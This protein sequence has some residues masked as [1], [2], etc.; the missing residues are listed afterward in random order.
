[1][2][3][4]LTGYVSAVLLGT[5]SAGTAPALVIHSP[6]FRQDV[7]ENLSGATPSEL[8]GILPGRRASWRM[9]S[10][11]DKD[12]PGSPDDLD[13]PFRSSARDTFRLVGLIADASGAAEM[14]ERT[15]EDE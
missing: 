13:G 3:L 10:R 8:G 4:E 6:G 1:M 12:R 14:V 9:D 2:P 15:A 7:Y 5:D 11:Y